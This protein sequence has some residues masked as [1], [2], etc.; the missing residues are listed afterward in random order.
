MG[1]PR[2]DIILKGVQPILPAVIAI[3]S[4]RVMT[5]METLFTITIKTVAKDAG[6]PGMV[7]NQVIIGRA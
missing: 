4:F 2:T 7:L 6:T 5:T 1:G 3:P